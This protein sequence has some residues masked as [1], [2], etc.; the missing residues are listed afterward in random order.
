MEKSW[1]D[2]SELNG[3]TVL[4]RSHASPDRIRMFEGGV[5]YTSFRF[6]KATSAVCKN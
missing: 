6:R 4:N 1:L 2:A 3:E 5:A